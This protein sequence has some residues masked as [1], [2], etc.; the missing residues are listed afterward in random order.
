LNEINILDPF[1]LF[2]DAHDFLKKIE[3][4]NVVDEAFAPGIPLA[5]DELIKI[6]LWNKGSLDFYLIQYNKGINH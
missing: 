4:W 5:I 3:V 6:C 2:I 1:I